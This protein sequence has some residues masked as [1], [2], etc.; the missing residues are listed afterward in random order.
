M[1]EQCVSFF[2]GI[3]GGN[4]CDVHTH[5]LVYLVDINFGEDNLLGDA[6]CVVGYGEERHG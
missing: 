2:V 5:E 1:L 4:E 3:G 6:Q